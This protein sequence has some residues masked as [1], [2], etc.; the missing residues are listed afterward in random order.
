PRRPEE[1]AAGL[2]LADERVVDEPRNAPAVGVGD[3]RERDLVVLAVANG[4]DETRLRRVDAER[5]TDHGAL[6][7]RRRVRRRCS[8]RDADATEERL[9]MRRPELVDGV[10]YPVVLARAGAQS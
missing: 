9:Q 10:A 2:G 5:A 6:G 4:I 8:P 7:A 1:G 3:G